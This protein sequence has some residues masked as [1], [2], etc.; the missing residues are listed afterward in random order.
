MK[1]SRAPWIASRGVGVLIAF[2]FSMTA[3]GGPAK[4]TGETRSIRV[5]YTFAEIPSFGMTPDQLQALGRIQNPTKDQEIYIRA[6]IKDASTALYELS[7]RRARIDPFDYVDNIKNADL[8]ISLTGDPGRGGWATPGGIEGRPGQVGLYYK[9]LEKSPQEQAAL[10][11]A[12]ELSHYVYALPD[13]YQDGEQQG[14]CPLSNPTGPGCLMDNYFL[15]RGDYGRYCD[16]D[17]NGSAPN[18]NHTGSRAHAAAILQI[19]GG[20]LLP[21]ASPR[22]PPIPRRK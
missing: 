1:T 8:V 16:T 14:L 22:P 6:L 12:H 7:D 10:T 19:L 4:Y 2:V 5:T 17:H 11:V 20:S 21:V 9:V 13:E 3:M 18:P 15:R